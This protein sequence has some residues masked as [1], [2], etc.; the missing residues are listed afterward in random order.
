MSPYRASPA[1]PAQTR[2]SKPVRLMLLGARHLGG[3]GPTIASILGIPLALLLNDLPASIVMVASAFI[4]AAMV[5]L[6][7]LAGGASRVWRAR[8]LMRRWAQRAEDDSWQC[9]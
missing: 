4:G 3:M 8:R 1:C 7:D 2:S 5:V 9:T 6:V